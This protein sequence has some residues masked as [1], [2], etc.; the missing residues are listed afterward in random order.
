MPMR[1][2]RSLLLKIMRFRWRRARLGLEKTYKINL[3][4]KM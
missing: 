3:K 1:F 2:F 4:A